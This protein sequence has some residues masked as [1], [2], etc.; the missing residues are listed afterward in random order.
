MIYR[1]E[2]STKPGLP[3]ARGER[4]LGNISGVDSLAVTD[5]YFF[6][7]GLDETD[8]MRLVHTL[9]YDPVVEQVRW[10][11]LDDS[12][13]APD[14][15]AGGWSVEVTL[16]PGVTDSVAESLLAA[17]EVIGVAGLEQVATGQRYDLT[18]DL[19]DAAVQRIAASL[20]ANE[21]VQTWTIDG[22][23][24]PP[25]VV[26]AEL[27]A[28]RW[29]ETIALTG[30]SSDQLLAISQERR[31]SLD[32]AEMQAIQEYYRQ[33]SREP[34]DVELETL[35][36]TWSE[37]CVHKTFRALID[38]REIDAD[39]NVHE[40][41]IDS[42]LKTYIRAATERANKPWV[43][44]AFVDN[45]GIVVFDDDYDLAFKVE[46]HNHRQ[47]WSR[48]AAPTPVSAASCAT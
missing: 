1:V 20:L 9:L 7:G 30:A 38:Y 23:A 36:Q 48:S 5:L 6:K 2:V 39:G 42:L 29:V 22:R 46:T 24:L 33:E 40:Q 41:Q 26:P 4:L 11:A 19:T 34:T 14:Q 15:P 44:S 31:L 17:A 16:L 13:A 27:S 37:H 28:G 18:G 25:F 45:A 21:V 8:V 10:F 3:D 35:A 32:L 43:R 47:R 12:R